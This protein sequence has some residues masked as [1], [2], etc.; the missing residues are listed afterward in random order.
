[1]TDKIIPFS[2]VDESLDNILSNI[3]K[4]SLSIEELLFEFEK[5]LLLNIQFQYPK[6]LLLAIKNIIKME[7]L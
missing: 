3:F 5:I 2:L 4:T 6:E 1:M 7:E